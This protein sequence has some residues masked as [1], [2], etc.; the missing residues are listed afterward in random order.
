MCLLFADTERRL[1]LSIAYNK[2][3]EIPTFLTGQTPPNRSKTQHRFL[4]TKRSPLNA[5][6]LASAVRWPSTNTPARRTEQRWM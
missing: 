5:Q 3:Q 6:L 1:Q 2:I 4:S